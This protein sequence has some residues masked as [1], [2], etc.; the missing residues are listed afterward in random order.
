MAL[1]HDTATER[2]R[3]RDMGRRLMAACRSRQQFE[4]RNHRRKARARFHWDRVGFAGLLRGRPKRRQPVCELPAVPNL[5][6]VVQGGQKVEAVSQVT[7]TGYVY[8]FERLTGRPLF[9]VEDR[10]M[11]ASDIPGEKAA[12][13]QPLPVKPPPFSRQFIGT[14]DL[15]DISTQTH[16]EVVRRSLGFRFGPSFTPP[17]TQG[18]VVVPGFHGGATWSGASVDPTTG[19]LYV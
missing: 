10:P 2:I 12:A 7:K 17:S 9:L 6:T 11:P 15:T 1:S 18:T 8:L 13:T 3:P 14:N 5:V 19:V 16:D 4:W